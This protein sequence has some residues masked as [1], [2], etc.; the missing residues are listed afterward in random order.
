MDRFRNAQTGDGWQ[1]NRGTQGQKLTSAQAGMVVG[2]GNESGSLQV[3]ESNRQ[4][5][6]PFDPQFVG[7]LFAASPPLARTK[8]LGTGGIE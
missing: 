1:D 3:S 8:N 4:L 7:R 6:L 5:G 2:F